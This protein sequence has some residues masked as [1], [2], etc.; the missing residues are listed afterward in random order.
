MVLFIIPTT[1]SNCEQS[2]V[3]FLTM[4]DEESIGLAQCKVSYSFNP[5]FFLVILTYYNV[6]VTKN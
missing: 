6:Y 5:A 2:V 3:A 1:S 4:E